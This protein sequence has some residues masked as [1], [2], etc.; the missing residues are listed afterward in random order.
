MDQHRF[1]PSDWRMPVLASA[2]EIECQK[3]K[4]RLTDTALQSFVLNW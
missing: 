3:L 4:C 1:D 2:T